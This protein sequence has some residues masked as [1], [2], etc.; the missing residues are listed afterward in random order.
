[1]M[2]ML[3]DQQR[4]KIEKLWSR[5]MPLIVCKAAGAISKVE[6]T[7]LSRR[8]HEWATSQAMITWIKTLM[9][10]L[11]LRY[12]VSMLVSLCPKL[13]SRKLLTPIISRWGLNP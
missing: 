1:M 13:I 8:T 10:T 4:V 2:E 9:L 11:E 3:V 6:S 12:L 7:S 5:I